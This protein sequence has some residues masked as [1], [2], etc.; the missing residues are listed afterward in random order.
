MNRCSAIEWVGGHSWTR[1]KE[2]LDFGAGEAVLFTLRFVAGVP[3]E[4][5]EMYVRLCGRPRAAYVKEV[6]IE[7]KKR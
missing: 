4:L 3:V 6:T 2:R 7:V 1:T 5:H